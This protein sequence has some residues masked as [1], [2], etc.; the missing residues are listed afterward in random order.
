[1][2]VVCMISWSDRLYVSEE[3]KDKDIKKIKENINSNTNSNS[4]GNNLHGVCS[5]KSI[6]CITFASNPKNLFDIYNSKQFKYKYYQKQDI[7][8]LGLAKSKK[9][10]FEVVKDMLLEIYERTGEFNVKEYFK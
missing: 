5:T 3:I 2:G 1:M 4:S 8:V 10:A 7:H 9:K 6:Y